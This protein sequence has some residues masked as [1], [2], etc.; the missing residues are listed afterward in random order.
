MTR[1]QRAALKAAPE[2]AKAGA[3]PQPS[4][5]KPSIYDELTAAV[6]AVE[7]EV[8][9]Q[10]TAF[11]SAKQREELDLAARRENR[12]KL[13]IAAALGLAALVVLHFIIINTIF[14][15]PTA[16]KLAAV[17][18]QTGPEILRLYSSTEQ[19]LELAGTRIEAGKRLNSDELDYIIAVTLR[20]R[21]ALFETADSNGTAVYRSH[22]VAIPLVEA[23]A[24]RIGLYADGNARQP[25]VL[26]KILRTTHQAG[27]PLVVRV[28]V[29]AHR[30][31]WSWT[32]RAPEFER[33]QTSRTL[34]GSVRA[35]HGSEPVLLIDSPNALAEIR[36]LTRQAKEYLEQVGRDL[37]ARN[38]AE[39]LR[40]P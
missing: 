37:A 32:F 10:S 7:Q 29:N 3:A 24:A 14:R 27:E 11:I 4:G 30:F 5:P 31:G 40:N 15:E 12:R 18:D 23:E 20:L 8:T 26:P 34:A 16:A 2:S 28:P 9:A 21:E 19:P 35:R 39:P 36:A 38:A 13:L 17:A 25:P 6:A 1:L 22:A 33:R